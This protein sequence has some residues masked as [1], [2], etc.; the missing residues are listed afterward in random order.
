MEPAIPVTVAAA[1][2]L[3][4]PDW[5]ALIKRKRSALIHP[6]PAGGGPSTDSFIFFSVHPTITL[7]ESATNPEAYTLSG[8]TLGTTF[9]KAA[10]NGLLI[11]RTT[12]SVN[13]SA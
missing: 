7:D 3:A 10:S 12:M 5:A 8:K 9:F 4:V 2:L 6:P 11:S 13:R 1:P